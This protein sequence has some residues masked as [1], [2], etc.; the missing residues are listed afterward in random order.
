MKDDVVVMS[1]VTRK[2]VSLLGIAAVLFAQLAVSV[3]A[4]PLQLAGS[5]QVSGAADTAEIDASG[6]DPASPA[7]CQKHCDNGQQNVNDVPASLAFVSFFPAFMISLPID[8]PAPLAATAPARSLLHATSP[9]H[10]IRNCC[11]RI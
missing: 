10:S 7:L 5:V 11:F 2:L 9:P 6:R 4:C 3:Y 8:P 1:R